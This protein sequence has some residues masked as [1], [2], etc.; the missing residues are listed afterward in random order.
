MS[1]E[2]SPKKTVPTSLEDRFLREVHC[3]SE[4]YSL[5]AKQAHD[6]YVRVGLCTA[7]LSSL[8]PV[9]A[10]TS[11]PRWVVTVLSAVVVTGHGFFALN[12]PH[13]HAIHFERASNILR[14]ELLKYEYCSKSDKVRAWENF[15]TRVVELEGGLVQQETNIDTSEVSDLSSRE[16]QTVDT[17]GLEPMPTRGRPNDPS[18]ALA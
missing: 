10:A 14:L 5:E 6:Q 4:K 18:P 17:D 12:R 7:A 15:V 1:G 2:N 8:I 16:I 9:A 11:S 3:T 13:E